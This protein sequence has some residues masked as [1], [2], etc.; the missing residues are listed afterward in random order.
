MERTPLLELIIHLAS[1]TTHRFFQNDPQL[2]EQTVQQLNPKIFSQDVVP[3]HGE[4][5]L[6]A[7]PGKLLEGVSV[8][9]NPLPQKWQ[10]FIPVH[11][12]GI[13]DS[14]EITEADYLMKRGR[15][16]PAAQPF[17]MLI[18]AEM[19]SGHRF[20]VEEVAGE[21]NPQEVVR[22]PSFERH[23]VHTI[24]TRPPLVCRRLGGGLSLWNRA[25][26]VGCMLSPNPAAPT[27]AFPA[28]FVSE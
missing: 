25:H 24:F 22:R 26:M 3:V 5:L 20:W 14:R 11:D 4:N 1:G 28:E 16:N 8:V 7:Y 21:S 23:I 27:S 13:A 17:T 19:A 15:L 6:A 18:A 12:L 2:V 10:D 9:I